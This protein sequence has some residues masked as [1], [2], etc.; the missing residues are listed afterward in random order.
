[1]DTRRI[2]ATGALA[3]LAIAAHGAVAAPQGASAVAKANRAALEPSRP[4]RFTGGEQVFSY[5]PGRLYEIWTAPLRVTTLSLGRGEDVASIAAGDTVRW[6]IAETRSGSGA[7][8]RT[9]ILIKPFERGLATNLVI[10]TNRRVYL[11]MLRSGA[12]GDF[13]LAASWTPEPPAP[14]PPPPAASPP[15]PAEPQILA[16]A[17]KITARGPRP[18]WTPTAV[19]TDG[20]RTYVALPSGATTGE[21]PT[22][23]VLGPDGEPKLVNQRQRGSLLIVDGVIDR[24]EL[25][26]GKQRPVQIVR[27]PE[28]AP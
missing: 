14:P 28:A 27:L 19:M 23:S 11:V 3:A 13:N 7:D 12:E 1:M 2:V 24:A 26:L 15:T 20:A 4:D 18:P 17:F 25:R 10:A 9:H 8:Q 22:L 6:Q 21:A 16:S 5:A